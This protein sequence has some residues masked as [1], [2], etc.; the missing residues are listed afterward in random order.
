MDRFID[1]HTHSTASDGSMSPAELVRHAKAVGLSAIALTDHD[2]IAGIGDALEEGRKIGLEVIPGIEISVDYKPEMHILGYF[3]N[4]TYG[5]ISGTLEKLIE[6]RSERNPK[7]IGRLRE[8]GFDIT[9]EEV[10]KEAKGSVVGR[11]HIAK[12]LVR[13]GFA[14]NMEEAFDKFLASG[15]SA[16]FKKDKLNPEEGINEIIQA[17]GIPVLAHPIFLGLSYKDLDELLGSLKRVGLKGIEANYVENTGDDTG[18]LLR[19]ALKHNLLA[20]GGSDFHGSYKTNI[21]IGK[22]RGN[23]K[24]LYEVVDKMRII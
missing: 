22:G 23:L 7:I 11:P 14:K 24:V 8:I 19:L 9:M 20:T 12:V 13:K 3:L 10:E 21:E 2:T 16:Y 1:L 17:G 6:N 18:N 15:R 4:N 5:N